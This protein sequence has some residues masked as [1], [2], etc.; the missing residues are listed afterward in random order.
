[1]KTQKQIL[2]KAAISNLYFTGV[3]IG[4]IAVVTISVS[5]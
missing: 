4:N 1:M 5:Q 3:H 2:N